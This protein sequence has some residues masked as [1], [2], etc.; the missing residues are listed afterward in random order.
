MNMIKHKIITL[1]TVS[2]LLFLM[3]GA[4]AK[5]ES[6]SQ[7]AGNKRYFDAWIAVNHP[8]AKVTPLG[9]CIISEE[10]GTGESVGKEDSFLFAR[11]TTTDLEGNVQSTTEKKL[12]Q[13]VGTFAQG[14]YY[15]EQVL[16]NNVNY[17]EAGVLDMLMGMK[18]GGTR[19][20]A[21]PGWLNVTKDY[22][23]AEEYLDNCTGEDV[24]YKVT[25]VGKC[26]NIYEWETSLLEDYSAKHLNGTDSTKY[27]YYYMQT[28]APASTSAMPDDTTFYINYTGRLLN[29][30]VFDT[31]IEDTAKVHGIYSSS[32]KYVPVDIKKAKNHKDITMGSASGGSGSTLVEG[33]SFCLSNLKNHEKGICAFY[34]SLGYGYK[35]SGSK[36][37]KFAPVVFEIE[38][39][40][41]P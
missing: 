20:A 29:G 4:C 32:K 11:Y 36:I 33:F 8:G 14:N 31:T 24:I 3:A 23:S 10:A 22:G 1:G 41:K 37:P 15:G 34:S 5:E 27:G 25:L 17:T 19:T 6:A 7:N 21:I 12:A 2:A 16:I 9:A 18:I 26:N 38:V 28:K 13:Q 35:G 39:V 30:Q 40:D